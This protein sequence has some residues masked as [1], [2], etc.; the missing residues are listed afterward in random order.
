MRIRHYIA[1]LSILITTLGYGQCANNNSYY[2]D[3]TP[4]GEGDTQTE[5]CAW[6]GDYYTVTVIDGSTYTFSTCGTSWDTMITIYKADGTYVDFNDD[7]CSW[8]SELTW[9]ADFDGVIWVLVDE[10]YCSSNSSCA[11]LSV[12]MDSAGGGGG[13]SPPANDDCANAEV[14]TCGDSV[15]GSTANATADTCED[16]GVSIDAPGVWYSFEG[17]DQYV[18]F[19]LCGATSYDSKLNIYSG[20]CAALLCRGGNDDVWG[21]SGNSSELTIYCLAGTT[22]YAFVQGYGGDTGTFTL[23]CTCVDSSDQPQDCSGGITICDDSTFGGNSA[24]DGD[25]QELSSQNNGCL[26]VEHQSQWFFFSPTTAGT[27]E[28]TITPSNGIDYDFSIWGPYDYITCP[29]T[30]DPLRCTYSALYEPTG[31]SIGAGDSSEPPS[32]DAWVEAI[33]VTEDDIDKY[34]VMLIDNWTADNTAYSF[35]WNLT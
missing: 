7:S 5:S 21:C 19:S 28:F 2:D 29:P 25:V 13:S 33:T 31:L 35:D 9:T 24:D 22:Y 27:I 1:L 12:T 18:T 26:T 20:T 3:L 4:S 10:Y 14:I 16:C 11:T 15:A 34:Y 6:G 17:N 30:E 8:Q 23:S 32:G